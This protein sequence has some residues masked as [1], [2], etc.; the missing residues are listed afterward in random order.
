MTTL[1]PPAASN[2][3][4][5]AGLVLAVLVLATVGAMKLA[6]TRA[7]AS[8]AGERKTEVVAGP[9]VRVLVAGGDAA[10]SALAF[11]GEAVPVAAT[12][13]FAKI[14]G[15]IKSI[16]VDKGSRVRKGDILCILESPETDQQTLALKATY[17]NLQ[18]TADRLREL[19]RQGIANAQDVDNAAAAAQVARKNLEAQN[20]SQGYE[21]VLA[22]FSGVVTARLVDVGAFIQN[23]SSSTASQPIV[24]LADSSRLRIDFFLDQ[25]TAAQ[26]KAGQEV[27]VSPSDRPD[28]VRKAKVDR[29]A[30]TLDPRT[31]T[32]LAE[33]ELDNR[34]G[35]ILGGDYVRVTLRLAGTRGQIEIPSEALLVRGTRPFVASLEANDRVKMLPVVLGADIGSRVR[36]PQGLA[37]GTRIILNPDPGL[38]DGDRVQ[39]MK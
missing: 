18:R 13:V 5:T 37:A 24:S 3:F 2:R 15:F 28:L 17:E 10:G 7:L 27:E 34:D 6:Q 19:G 21:R 38:K 29:V 20:V 31:R 35:A 9:R 11:Q 26:V 36:V 39:V 25:A 1:A 16:P 33:T 32:M 14:G 12:T 22:P 30:G 23:A 8:E 4:R